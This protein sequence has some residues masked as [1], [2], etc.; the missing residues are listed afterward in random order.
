MELAA[1]RRLLAES[2]E[3]Q[4]A[5]AD[6]LKVIGRSS[7]E[8]QAVLETLCET[9][10]RLC[11]AEMVAI[12]RARGDAHFQVANFGYPPEFSAYTKTLP[13][14]KGRGS[15]TGRV[16]LERDIV[17][18]PDALADPEYAMHEAQKIGSFR[19]LLGVPLLREGNPIG[20]II[21]LRRNV[22]PFDARQIELVT[23]FA[24]QAVIAIENARL[25]DEV[26]EK[27]RQLELA[28][29]YKSRF[30]AA[31][32]HDLRQPLHALNLFVAQLHAEL[33]SQE[34][35]RLEARIDAAVGSMNELFD[36]LLDMSKLDAGMIDPNLTS[37]PVANLLERIETTFTDAAV[38]K[39]LRLKVIP[40]KQWVRSDSI[41]LGR[42][43]FNLASNAI[44]Y[45]EHGGVVVGC[46]RHGQQLSI[47]V[48]DSGPG[49]AED[50]QQHV[51]D[52]FYQ[53]GE[54][55]RLG[56][57]GLGLSIVDRLARLLQHEVRLTSSPG[58]GS[59]FSVL[60]SL[61]IAERR[62]AGR[63]ASV[64]T[65]DRLRDRSIVVIDDD[66]L[67][68][69]G[70]RGMLEG[71]GCRVVAASSHAEALAELT[72]RALRPDLI[73]SDYHLSGRELGI[74]AV[75]ALS[76]A[77]GA[78]PSFFISGD[79]S[80]QRLREAKASGYRLLHKPISPMTL[81][82]IVSRFLAGST[83]PEPRL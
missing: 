37:F 51:F 22:R 58:R 54:S 31:A 14:S 47:D 67:V 33:D 81:R 53:V 1:S 39:G 9:A 56:G 17:H 6:V 68:L 20:V 61:A 35:G 2:R 43:L 18:I 48:H 46:R 75:K 79:T 80:G 30:L 8:L 44:R 3:Q 64:P 34:R 45:T 55:G 16:L 28:N 23:S 76:D 72:E 21:L 82:A 83:V 73:I 12:T 78:I 50:Q 40:S 5:T 52:E 65:I 49:I 10:T 74:G 32:S 57:M 62:E 11:E 26:Q 38:Q 15:L 69:E 36:A 25:F 27:S 24:D 77:F 60:V 70:M 13:L 66:V 7:F 4:A 59:R 29:V 71:W 42:I 41:L 63:P 19:T